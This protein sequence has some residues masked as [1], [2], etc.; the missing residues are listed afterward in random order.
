M[1][2]KRHAAQGLDFVDSEAFVG[3]FWLSSHMICSI[4]NLFIIQ[5]LKKHS[6]S[7]WVCWASTDVLSC[8][9]P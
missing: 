2:T 6:G 1:G 4:V 8:Q 7:C 5:V 9:K 3:V